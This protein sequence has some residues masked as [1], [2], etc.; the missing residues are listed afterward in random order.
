MKYYYCKNSTSKMYQVVPQAVTIVVLSP[1]GVFKNLYPYPTPTL[2]N[3]SLKFWEPLP[4]LVLV[5]RSCI[6]S[7]SSLFLSVQIKLQGYGSSSYRIALSL[8][9]AFVQVVI[10]KLYLWG[11]LLLTIFLSFYSKRIQK[12]P[13]QKPYLLYFVP[14]LRLTHGIGLVSRHKITNV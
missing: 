6:L 3:P 2:E 4:W 11:H 7:L 9:W 8:F 14:K 13:V 1:Y 12:M 5:L 10:F